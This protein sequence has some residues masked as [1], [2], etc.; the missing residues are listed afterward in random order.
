[1]KCTEQEIKASHI[2]CGQD[3][4]INVSAD[5][6]EMKAEIESLKRDAIAQAGRMKAAADTIEK[7]ATKLQTTV[8]V[9]RTA[10]TYSQSG[11]CTNRYGLAQ[12]YELLKAL[13][14]YDKGIIKGGRSIGDYK[15]F[16]ETC[17]VKCCSNCSH[18]GLATNYCRVH[19][20]DKDKRDICDSWANELYELVVGS[21]SAET[22]SAGESPAIPLPNT[23][24][25]I[26]THG[27]GF[28]KDGKH[29][30]LEDVYKQ[31][32]DVCKTCG[33]RGGDGEVE[34]YDDN[35]E[36]VKMGP[37]PDCKGKG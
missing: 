6:L 8:K 21:A 9:I 23:V 1:M 20:E 26:L 27:V 13:A 3:F 17:L 11:D 4:I 19:K 28:E 32:S 22:I 10:R 7:Q 15:K 34:V 29:I 5:W 36:F 37:C 12:K 16:I 31:P 33:C 25:D 30:P 24:K 14:D 18:H 2:V 35:F